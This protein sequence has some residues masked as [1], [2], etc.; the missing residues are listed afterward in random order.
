MHPDSVSLS[1]KRQD[2]RLFHRGGNQHSGVKE[3]APDPTAHK[4]RTEAKP[5]LTLKPTPFPPLAAPNLL[6]LH[7]LEAG[8][9]FCFIFRETPNLFFLHQLNFIQPARIFCGGSP[10]GS[11]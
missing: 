10:I 2:T 4:Q 11:L 7:V 6:E 3:L 5:S 1:P 9:E 8:P